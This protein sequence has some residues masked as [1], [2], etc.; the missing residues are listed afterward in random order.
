LGKFAIIIHPLEAKDIARH[1]A[2]A[3]Y[4]PGRVVEGIF[5]LIPPLKVSEITGIWSPFGQASGWFVYVPLTARKMLERPEEY[6]TGRII[7]A[8][9]I[10]EKLGAGIVGLEAFTSVVGDA[11]CTVE[12]SLKSAVTTGSSFTVA[13]ALQ[14]AREGSFL[15]GRNFEDA[16]VVVL[17]ATGPVGRVCAMILAGEVKRMTLVAREKGKLEEVAG[18]ILFESGL[19]VKITS[20][21]KKAL[22]AAAVVIDAA[23]AADTV[24]GAEDLPPGSVVCDVAQPRMVSGQ[25]A[26]VRDDV[27]FIEGGLVEVPGDVNF[28]FNFGFP[29]KLVSACMAETIVLAME[30]R[31]ESFSLGRQITVR[32][33]EEI[34]ALA[35]KH[36]FKLAGFKSFKRVLSPEEIE[37]I[38]KNA[39]K[40]VCRWY[41]GRHKGLE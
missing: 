2:P 10:A 4:L 37:N 17:G 8:G 16:H 5:S 25:V 41:K 12:R 11:G 20:D 31:Y 22:R 38:K 27:L 15:M 13:A 18:K 7:R 19:S 29:P 24:I 23:G 30:G 39:L 14:G 21:V 34:T 40:K 28:G 26:R 35:R 6:V 33:V 1:F 36:G 9:R 3:G 32:Q